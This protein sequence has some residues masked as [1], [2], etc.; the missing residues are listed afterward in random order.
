MDVSLRE[1]TRETL[2]EILKLSVESGQEQYV[3]N[4]AV[5]IAQAHF[6]EDAWFRG[7]YDGDTPVGFVMISDIPEKA[8][9]YLWRFMIDEHHQ[10]KGFG[11]RALELLIEHVRTR[12]NATHL[13]TSYKTGEGSPEGF[14]L[15]CGFVPT[16]DVDE[17]GE[18]L[19]RIEL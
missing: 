13:Y 4:N 11:T 18:H 17:Y 3:S 2:R 8:E 14:Y 6:H 7:I 16:G 5:S 19:A 12:P 10:R 1:I 9:Y 15:R